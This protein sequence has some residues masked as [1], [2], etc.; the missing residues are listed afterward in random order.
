MHAANLTALLGATIA[1]AAPSMESRAAPTLQTVNV[2]N[3]SSPHLRH[4]FTT[5]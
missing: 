4:I 5:S 2:L 3:N 1:A